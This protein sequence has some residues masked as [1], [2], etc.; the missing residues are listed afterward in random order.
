MCV[1]VKVQ[2]AKFSV[3]SGVRNLF[4]MVSVALRFDVHK[5]PLQKNTSSRTSRSTDFLCHTETVFNI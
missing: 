5:Y 4:V 2:P 1:L 3:L